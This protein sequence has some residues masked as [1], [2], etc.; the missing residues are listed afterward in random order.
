MKKLISADEAKKLVCGSKERQ[1]ELIRIMNNLIIEQAQQGNR[2]AH[3]PTSAN[4]VER[5][6]LKDELRAAGFE[7][8]QTNPVVNW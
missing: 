8:K 4:E 6:W 7:I 1:D 5:E 3:L 2:W